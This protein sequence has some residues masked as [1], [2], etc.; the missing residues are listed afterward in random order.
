MISLIDQYNLLCEAYFGI[1]LID[2]YSLKV[3]E[4]KKVEELINNF[5]KNYKIDNFDYEK[6]FNYVKDTVE[7]FIEIYKSDKTI[8][9]EINIATQKEISIEE[10][11][12]ELISQINPDARIICDE[13]RLRPEKSE[14]ERLLGSNE[15]IKELTNWRPR[16][17]L[18]QGLRE[19]IEFMGNNLNK[20][21]TDI[22]NL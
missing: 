21:K 8:G 19:T 5:K 1:E 11:A 15:K 9:Q 20:Y 2:E 4:L 6:H 3:Y 10:L 18:E 22:Y 12:K 16:Y 7:G 13:Q 14:V 17:T